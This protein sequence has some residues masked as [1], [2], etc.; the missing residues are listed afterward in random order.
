MLNNKT[1][2]NVGSSYTEGQDK[3]PETAAKLKAL[4]IDDDRAIHLIHK[5]NF[6]DENVDL[7]CVRSPEN[8]IVVIQNA[9]QPDIILCDMEM[10]EGVMTGKEFYEWVEANEPQLLDRIIFVS[11]GAKTEEGNEFLGEMGKKGRWI[12]K[13]HIK[14][15]RIRV[16][17]K[18]VLAK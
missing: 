8:A 5:H 3:S 14:L 12:E 15:E 6:R 9:D 7:Q 18:K 10:G 2:D 13:P 17:I 1:P 11:G 4:A 16:A